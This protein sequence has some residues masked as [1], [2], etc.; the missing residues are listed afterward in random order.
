LSDLTDSVFCPLFSIPGITPESSIALASNELDVQ[1]SRPRITSERKTHPDQPPVS[2]KE[3][4]WYYAGLPSS[5]RLV[6]RSSTPTTPWKEPT[7]PEAYPVRKELKG[8][9]NHA[10]NDVWEDKLAPLILDILESERV[11]FTSVDVVRIGAVGERCPPVILWIGVLPESLTPVDGLDVALQCKELLEKNDIVDVDVELRESIVTRSAGPR[12]LDPLGWA[13][14]PDPTVE[15][16]MPLTAT[17]GLGI[18]AQSTSWAEGTGGFYMAE[19]GDSKRI[20]LVTARHVVFPPNIVD[21]NK[22]EYENPSQPRRNVLLLGDN[23]FKKL[24]ASIQSEIMSAAINE[25]Y[26][27]RRLK[28]IEKTEEVGQRESAR[29][30]TQAALDKTKKARK[31]HPLYCKDVLESWGPAEER[32]LGH[33]LYAPPIGVG[34]TADQHTEDFAVIALDPSKIDA[35]NFKGNV[36]DLGT[37]YTF[38]DFHHMMNSHLGPESFEYPLDRL[39]PLQGTISTAELR[40]P[41]LVDKNGEPCV[42]VLK[43]G[44]ATDL[45]IGRGNNVFSF[46]RHYFKDKEPQTS[47]EWPVL[48]YDQKSNAFSGQGDSGAVVVDGRGRIGGLIT[49]GGGDTDDFD[50]TYATPIEFLLQRIAEQFPDAHLDPV[51]TA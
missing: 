12:F 43:R 46:V 15:L 21:N 39:L 26:L 48:P 8:V 28:A 18:C 29:K 20:L 37:K 51:L 34:A 33:V 6:A 19:G 47:K 9:G 5:P 44:N 27:P 30:D 50:V 14:D 40:R 42:I 35:K 10:L 38:I 25:E 32:V 3:S 31:E 13:F 23:A 11:K 24:L 22:Y 49:S 4:Y 7:G 41:T 16:H 2:D 45:T 36:I 1:L 17:L